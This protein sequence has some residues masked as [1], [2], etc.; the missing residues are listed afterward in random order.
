M[1]PVFPGK[2]CGSMPYDL[3][4]AAH[5]HAPIKSC[6][7]LTFKEKEFSLTT[8]K[9]AAS[10]PQ[11]KDTTKKDTTHLTFKRKKSFHLLLKKMRPT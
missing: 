4:A 8:K 11:V 7:P 9:D 5:L 2:R 6:D 10:F 1:M 3:K